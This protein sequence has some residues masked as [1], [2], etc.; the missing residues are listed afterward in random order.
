MK[1][2]QNIKKS[3]I[4]LESKSLQD[5]KNTQNLSPKSLQAQDLDM[6]D[7]KDLLYSN[8][9]F[10]ERLK[11]FYSHKRAR[12]SS[13]IFLFLLIISLIAPFIANERPIF[14]YKD[15]RAF[16]PI[17]KNYSE[18]D[19]GGDFLTA[20]DFKDPFV[21][22]LLRKSFV[23]Y[24]L[25]QYSPDS[26]DWNLGK[27][28]PTSLSFTH[29]LGTDDQGRDVLTRLLYGLRTSLLFGLVLSVFSLVIGVSIGAIQGYYGGLIDLLGQRGI[30]IW[31]GMPTLF[32]IIIISSFVTP[33]FWLILAVV[34]LFSWM[35]IVGVV[36]AEFLRARVND[37]VLACKSMGFGSTRIIFVHILPNA[38]VAT[39]T[40]MPFI[41]AGSITALVSL[42]F[43]GFGM[44]LGSASLGELLNQGKNNINS[45]HLGIIGFLS[46]AILL[47]TLVFIGEG[48]RTAFSQNKF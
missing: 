18:R 10:I 31:S 17:F 38:L 2:L 42:D 14:I 20:P 32:L 22:N 6:Q 41:M 1:F 44:P 16:F 28:P 30:E 23:I 9:I 26:I 43:L 21:I 7:H 48:V 35:S 3:K 36:R 29:W 34:L 12:Y 45:P 39:I 4:F 24:P 19:L 37:Y 47:S 13:Y 25:I 8:S 40:Y 46:T 27:T 11:R 15:G 33:G 5:C